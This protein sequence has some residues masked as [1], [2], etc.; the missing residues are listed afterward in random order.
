MNFELK[1]FRDDKAQPVALEVVT[2]PYGP[3]VDA[4]SKEHHLGAF[5]KENMSGE[6]L[7]ENGMIF[8]SPITDQ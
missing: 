8:V 2:E 4:L 5:F 3:R 6:V 7:Y 1:V